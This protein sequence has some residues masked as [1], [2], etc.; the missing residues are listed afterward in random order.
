LPSLTAIDLASRETTMAEKKSPWIKGKP[1]GGEADKKADAP[2]AAEAG[3]R[4][5]S[6]LYDKEKRGG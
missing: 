5:G 3:K 2:K 4:R 1:K 6:V